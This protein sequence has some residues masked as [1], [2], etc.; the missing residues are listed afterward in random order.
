MMAG[1]GC[2]VVRHGLMATDDGRLG[3]LFAYFH[4]VVVGM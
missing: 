2:C 1:F 4:G 3:A